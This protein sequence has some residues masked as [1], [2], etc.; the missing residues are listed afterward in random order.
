[1][2][3]RM[4]QGIYSKSRS[5]HT[6]DHHN[7]LA[8]E[9]VPYAK[10]KAVYPDITKQTMDQYTV[11]EL[12]ADPK[13]A[14]VLGTQRIIQHDH[15]ESFYR[16]LQELIDSR[17]KALFKGVSHP[18]LKAQGPGI[19]YW[20]LIKVVRLYVKHHVFKAGLILVDLPGVHDSNAA[21][22][23]VADDYMKSCSGLFIVSPIT[24][25]VDD[26]SAKTLLGDRFRRQVKMDGGFMDNMVTFICSKTDDISVTETCDALGLQEVFEEVDEQLSQ[27]KKECRDA[28]QQAERL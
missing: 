9:S 27:R 11:D 6:A 3:H 24:R 4:M 16:E 2:L 18:K 22:A 5:L 25:A 23:K 7:S 10:L 8:T 1:V 19:A 13:V 26:K 28:F 20:P 21:R 14:S 15:V 17:D 12:M